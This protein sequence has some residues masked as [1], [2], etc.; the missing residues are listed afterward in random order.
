MFVNYNGDG[1]NAITILY[2]GNESSYTW[3]LTLRK[4]MSCVS[5]FKLT[6][7]QS[8]YSVTTVHTRE[9]YFS[10]Q[11]SEQLRMLHNI[12]MLRGEIKNKE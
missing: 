2:T 7:K 4:G 3:K 12:S 6:K 11:K 8:C 5:P 1:M 9:I 10:S